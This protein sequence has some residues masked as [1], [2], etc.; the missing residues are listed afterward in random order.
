MWVLIFIFNFLIAAWFYSSAR[1]IGKNKI[2]WFF[3]GLLTCFFLGI[4][5]LKFGELYILPLETSVSDVFRDRHLKTYLE[6]ATMVLI[7]GYAYML[8]SIFLSKKKSKVQF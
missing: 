6:I 7:S 3:I 4:L 5:F 1:E 2:L 8:R